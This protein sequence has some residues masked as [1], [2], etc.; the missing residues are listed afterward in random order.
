MFDF[1]FSTNLDYVNVIF[2]GEGSIDMFI[3]QTFK[4]TLN[5]A[6]MIFVIDFTEIVV[7]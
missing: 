1:F 5:S 2:V 3:F 7:A 6:G 4:A